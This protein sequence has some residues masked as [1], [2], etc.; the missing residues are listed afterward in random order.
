L[1]THIFLIWNKEL[2]IQSEIECVIKQASK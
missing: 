1:C 2:Y